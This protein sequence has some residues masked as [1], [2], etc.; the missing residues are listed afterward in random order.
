MREINLQS[1][2]KLLGGLAIHPFTVTAMRFVSTLEE[3][4]L[5]ASNLTAVSFIGLAH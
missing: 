1:V 5:W 4:L 2:G 3:C